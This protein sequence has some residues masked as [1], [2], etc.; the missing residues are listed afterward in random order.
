MVFRGW[1]TEGN[2]V[3]TR[4]TFDGAQTVCYNTLIEDLLDRRKRYRKPDRS[5]FGED[6][7]LCMDART[8]EEIIRAYLGAADAAKRL[9]DHE[10]SAGTVPWRRPYEELE[11]GTF[12]HS[13]EVARFINGWVKMF[14]E[15][16]DPTVLQ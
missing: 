3:H 10:E 4:Q 2:M 11:A 9:M 5:I 15:V 6:E 16:V 13:D 12:P 14:Y 1:N 7:L 8:R